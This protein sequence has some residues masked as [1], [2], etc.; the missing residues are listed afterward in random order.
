MQKEILKSVGFSLRDS[1]DR[2]IAD[3]A[4][5]RL[6]DS[7]ECGDVTK[8]I[9]SRWNAHNGLVADN[10]RLRE[11]LHNLLDSCPSAQ[12]IWDKSRMEQF[13][14]AFK[15]ACELLAQSTKEAA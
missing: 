7:K 10:A 2:I 11:A 14:N 6:M 5:D 1:K 13:E 8:E 4:A 15:S 3:C 12:V 9:C